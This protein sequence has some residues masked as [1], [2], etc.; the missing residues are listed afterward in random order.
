MWVMSLTVHC[1][2]LWHLILEPVQ[3]PPRSLLSWPCHLYHPQY[4]SHPCNYFIGFF[5]VLL[6]L[7]VPWLLCLSPFAVQDYSRRHTGKS[8]QQF[9]QWPQPRSASPPPS[10][11]L[12]SHSVLPI[13]HSWGKTN[14]FSSLCCLSCT[15]APPNA[16][17]LLSPFPNFHNFH[18]EIRLTTVQLYD[19]TSL[20]SPP[21]PPLAI[22]C[23]SLPIAQA[24]FR[25]RPPTEHLAI[26]T[27]EQ[28]EVLWRGIT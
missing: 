27:T 2:W 26:V 12:L 21:R 16:T 3:P 13:S 25:P 8:R 19:L 23:R 28:A 6:C 15:P 4:T 18:S 17:I 1:P 20:V 7:L 10:L 9:F 5:S 14:V 22:C 24:G 11:C